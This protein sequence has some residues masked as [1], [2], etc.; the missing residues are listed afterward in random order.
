MSFFS[1][2]SLPLPHGAVGLSVF[3]CVML[4]YPGHTHLLY[5]SYEET[6]CM[7]AL[8]PIMSVHCFSLADV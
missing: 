3:T 2:H 5:E 4:D 1:Y 8:R 6:N 7:V